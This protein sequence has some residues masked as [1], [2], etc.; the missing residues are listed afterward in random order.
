MNKYLLDDWM[1]EFVYKTNVFF[2]FHIAYCMYR[3]G[4]IKYITP[5]RTYVRKL[6]KIY[7]L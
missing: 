1:H 3:L 5:G 2:Q 6:R 4:R 7:F